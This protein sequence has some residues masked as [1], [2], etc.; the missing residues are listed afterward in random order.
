[1]AEVPRNELWMVGGAIAVG[2]LL[3]LIYLYSIR[4]VRLGGDE[5]EY[6]L[7]GRL[8]ASGHWLW[9]TTPYGNPHPTLQKAPLYPAWVGLWYSILGVHPDRVEAVQT[10]F[11]PVNIV[12]SWLLARRLFGA[13]AGLVAAWIVALDPPMFQWETRLYSESI[14]TPL[15]VLFL[16]VVLERRPTPR[17]AAAAGVILGLNLLDRPMSVFLVVGLAAAWWLGAGLRRGSAFLALS[18]GVG[19]LVVAPWTIRNYVIDGRFV[20]I[21]AQDAVALA[22][23]FNSQSAHNPKYP[24]GWEPLPSSLHNIYFRSHPVNDAEFRS[25]LLSRGRHYIEAHPLSLFAAFWFNGITRLWEIR[26]P[27]QALDEIKPVPGRTYVPTL[28][29][30]CIYYVIF[31]L[32]LVSLWRHRHRRAL[33]TPVLALALGLSLAVTPDSGTRYRITLEPLI[34]VLACGAVPSLTTAPL[35]AKGRLGA[36]RLAARS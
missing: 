6:N 32:A 4:H 17:R 19:A 29:G 27:G 12:L 1:V 26:S 5:L 10:L 24:Y 20:P 36:P 14:A 18:L 35:R 8:A 23:T 30:L 15:I 3:R 33:V 16:V 9:S 28:I 22:G 11:G 31:A 2:L 34:A 13:R 25:L 21:S 7:E